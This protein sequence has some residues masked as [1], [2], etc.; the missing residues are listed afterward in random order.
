MN[1]PKIDFDL[2]KI[3][4]PLD[5]ILPIRKVRNPQ[6]T[7]GRFQTIVASVKELGL[8]EPLMV[9]PEKNKS[10][11]YLLMDGHLRFY[12]LKELGITEADCII[13]HQDESFTFNAR[14]NRVS[15]IQE[16]G[17]IMRAVKN[18]VTPERIAAALNL[19][20]D[21]IHDTLNLLNGI[22]PEAIEIIKDKQVCQSAIRMLKK[23][24]PLRQI[25]IAELMIT[26]NN[27]S[28]GYAHALL[29]GTPADQLIAPE[30][31][32]QVKGLSAEEVARMEQEMQSAEHDFKAVEQSY[33]EN[34]LNLTLAGAYVKKLLLNA[35][36]IR[37]LSSKHPE[38]FSV[39][40]DVAA[41]ETL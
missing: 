6:K 28:Q 31:S 7:I 35:K 13:C 8:I 15:P 17:M 23:V 19:K 10:G 4:L 27:F 26:A 14:I 29:M 12:A 34:V 3:R 41:M 33:G 32:K 21:R 11:H 39:F 5:V 38:I 22:H 24:I 30:K 37:F 9:F 18:G 2:K 1:A 40:E 20:V 25:E 16:H 36:V